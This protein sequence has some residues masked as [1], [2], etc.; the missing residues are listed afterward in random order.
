[1]TTITITKTSDDNYKEI[2]CNGHAGYAEYGEDIVCAAV[3]VLTI[4]TINSIEQLTKDKI[5]MSNNSYVSAV[6]ASDQA[7]IEGLTFD[8][9]ILDEAQKVSNYTWSERIAPMG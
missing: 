2:E 5:E 7:N 9:I 4:N 3:S 1:M 8:V 6:S